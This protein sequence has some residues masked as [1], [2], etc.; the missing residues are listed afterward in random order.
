MKKRLAH[1]WLART[2]SE[3]KLLLLW[4][5]AV[6]GALVYFALISPLYRRIQQLENTLPQLENQLFAM[7]SQPAP[8][9]GKQIAGNVENIDLRSAVFQFIGKQQL[10][11]DVRSI[12]A[13]RV[14]LRLPEMPVGE[15]LTLL[16]KLR[17]ETAARII[18]MRMK[19]NAARDAVQ[20]VVEMERL[21]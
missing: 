7:R 3:R 2:P 13:D 17:Q 19:N 11:A 4:S 8:V 5:T 12:S 20:V 21:S 9:A 1:F 14:E 16:E 6:L 10:T 15:A 18:V